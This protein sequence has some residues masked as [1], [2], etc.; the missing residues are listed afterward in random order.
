MREKLLTSHLLAVS[1]ASC[2]KEEDGRSFV[3]GEED[4]PSTSKPSYADK[5]KYG[6]PK[7]RNSGSDRLVYFKRSASREVSYDR[8]R[9]Y[10]GRSRSRSRSRRERRD[11]TKSI[12]PRKRTFSRSRSKSLRTS[13]HSTSRSLSPRRIKKRTRSSSSSRSRS[14]SR[15][16]RS[17]T[18]SSRSPSQRR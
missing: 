11:R 14:R 9:S 17:R 3:L 6:K 16:K 8:V 12:S 5:V 1:A 4:P 2:I 13:R 15:S 10:N 18:R 7:R